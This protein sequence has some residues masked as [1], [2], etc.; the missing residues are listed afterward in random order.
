MSGN[1]KCDA[2][3]FRYRSLFR[4][5]NISCYICGSLK[6]DACSTSAYELHGKSGLSY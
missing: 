1:L 6:C 3:T 2:C 5:L 4:L